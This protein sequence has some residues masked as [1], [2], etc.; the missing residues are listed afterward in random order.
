MA[1]MGDGL[2]GFSEIQPFILGVLL[3]W[4]GI[5]KIQSP[6]ARETAQESALAMLFSPSIARVGHLLL[7][8]IEGVR[9]WRFFCFPANW[10][11]QPVIAVFALPIT[12]SM[13]QIRAALVDEEK[14]QVLKRWGIEHTS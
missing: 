11:G 10:E 14:N 7:G 3:I 8:L 12:G 1:P 9:C 2:K 4:A 13:D 6:H 5:W